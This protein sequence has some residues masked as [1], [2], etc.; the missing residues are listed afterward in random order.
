MKQGDIARMIC[1][2]RLV[3]AGSDMNQWAGTQGYDMAEHDTALDCLRERCA[4][5]DDSGGV[6][7][8]CTMLGISAIPYLSGG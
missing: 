7:G 4:W 8:R 2:L 1:P 5:W 3:A 6:N